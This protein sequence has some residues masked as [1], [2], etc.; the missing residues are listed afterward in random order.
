MFMI[1]DSVP[2]M[3]M[4]LKTIRPDF[5]FRC[6]PKQNNQ[7]VFSFILLDTKCT[8][9]SLLNERITKTFPGNFVIILLPLF[10]KDAKGVFPSELVVWTQS[11]V[12]H[13]CKTIRPPDLSVLL[14]LIVQLHS[15]PYI[16]LQ[17]YIHNEQSVEIRIN[18]KEEPYTTTQRQT[19]PQLKTFKCWKTVR[20]S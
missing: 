15:V 14:R 4:H 2:K 5:R 9:I 12:G 1:S 11:N 18:Q 13:G 19:G 10:A 3:T 8:F 16:P 7:K 17:H 20:W 6:F